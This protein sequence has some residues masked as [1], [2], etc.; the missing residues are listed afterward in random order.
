[1]R[2]RMMPSAPRVL[3]TSWSA[4]MAFNLDWIDSDMGRI[5]GFGR[6]KRP[7]AAMLLASTPNV[8]ASSVP[9]N[10][11]RCANCSKR[12]AGARMS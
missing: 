4:R 6:Q 2:V 5:S 3:A 11:T 8:A 1:M 10:T 12:S 9:C 7:A